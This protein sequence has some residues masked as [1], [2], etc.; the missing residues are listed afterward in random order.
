M[1][2]SVVRTVVRTSQARVEEVRTYNKGSECKCAWLVTF[3]FA[4]TQASPQ[5][6]VRVTAM[7]MYVCMYTGGQED[8][9][10]CC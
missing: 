5:K 4:C 1:V 6:H 8:E 3:T 10:C 7:C 2:V 9:L